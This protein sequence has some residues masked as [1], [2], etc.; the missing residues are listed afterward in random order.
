[1]LPD[2]SL[3][4]VYRVPGTFPCVPFCPIACSTHRNVFTACCVLQINPDQ[5]SRYRR[6]VEWVLKVQTA[7]LMG[8]R[9]STLSVR[10]R[11]L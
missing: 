10:L 4:S 11:A 7:I 8:W 3:R 9:S 5:N 1:M 2:P 6:F